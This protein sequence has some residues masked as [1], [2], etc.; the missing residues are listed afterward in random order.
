MSTEAKQT[1]NRL[2]FMPTRWSVG[3]CMEAI[4]E[5]V[6]TAMTEQCPRNWSAVIWGMRDRRGNPMP[7]M[8]L[9]KAQKSQRGQPSVQ[10][11]FTNTAAIVKWSAGHTQSPTL[12]R[13]FPT[14]GMPVAD[15]AR[16]ITAWTVNAVNA[17]ANS[18]LVS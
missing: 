14:K 7:F 3:M 12:R 13:R 11:T 1:P 15:V 5:E 6:H 4:M 8:S 10:V 9:P 2:D 16:A 18:G 17:D